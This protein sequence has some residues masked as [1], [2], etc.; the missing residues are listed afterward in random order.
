M[1]NKQ[2]HSI[3]LF[4][5]RMITCHHIWANILM[6]VVNTHNILAVVSCSLLQESKGTWRM[7]EGTMAETDVYSSKWRHNNNNNNISKSWLSLQKFRRGN[8]SRMKWPNCAMLHNMYLAKEKGFSCG[9]NPST[10]KSS[11]ECLHANVLCRVAFFGFVSCKKLS[12]PQFPSWNPYMIWRKH[13]LTGSV[14]RPLQKGK[15]SSLV[16]SKP[17]L[18]SP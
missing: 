4:T 1:E 9:V 13:H 2:I 6:L 12:S 18:A 10:L 17:F 14:S 3:F 11:S 15:P 7:P 5:S 8:L 16:K